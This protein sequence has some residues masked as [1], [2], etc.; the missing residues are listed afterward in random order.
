[1]TAIWESDHLAAELTAGEE[2]AAVERRLAAEFGPT[3]PPEVVHRCVVDVALRFEDSR[4]RQYVPVL[5]ERIARAWLR[6]A[7]VEAGT[8]GPVGAETPTPA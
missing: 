8:R 6:D 3:V 7:V 2:L 5:V 1:M 4:V